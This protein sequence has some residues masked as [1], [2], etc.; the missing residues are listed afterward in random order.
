MEAA[1]AILAVLALVVVL[2][3][4]ISRSARRQG[5]ETAK[6]EQ[7]ETAAK[8]ADNARKLREVL[9]L[10]TRRMSDDELRD[11]MRDNGYLK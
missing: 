1:L 10:D 6:R 9:E 8:E 4:F 11:W 3:W 2:V 7:L 5:A